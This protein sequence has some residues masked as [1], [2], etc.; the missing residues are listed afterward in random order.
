[1]N[2]AEPAPTV[3]TAEA[4]PIRDSS[5]A[6]AEPAEASD[7]TTVEPAPEVEP[8]E[9]TDDPRKH[10]PSNALRYEKTLVMVIYLVG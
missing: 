8:A 1:M 5:G 10:A 2:L 3:E 4:E 9:T 6:F 7:E